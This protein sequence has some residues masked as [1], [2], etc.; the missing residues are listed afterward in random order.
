MF[1]QSPGLLEWRIKQPLS[2]YTVNYF[3]NNRSFC[4]YEVHKY[5]QKVKIKYMLLKLS[6][7]FKLNAQ[8]V[9]K[10]LSIYSRQKKKDYLNQHKKYLWFPTSEEARFM[11]WLSMTFH[12]SCHDNMLRGFERL[13]AVQYRLKGRK[14]WYYVTFKGCIILLSLRLQGL[15]LPIF[16]I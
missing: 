1:L 12:N 11:L 16:F 6:I 9:M 10:F 8:S 4:H 2:G 5:S 7:Y 3:G 15:G 14:K 13:I